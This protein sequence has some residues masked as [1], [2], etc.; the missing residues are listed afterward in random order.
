MLFSYTQNIGRSLMVIF[1]GV[2]L[3]CA[4]GRRLKSGRAGV[5]R[6]GEDEIKGRQD[7]KARHERLH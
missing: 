2:R 5:G 7:L 6:E 1:A 3:T 4:R